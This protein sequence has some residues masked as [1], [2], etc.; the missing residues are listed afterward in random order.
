MIITAL[1]E[2]TTNNP[3]LGVEHGLSL[4]IEGAHKNILFD[5]GASDLFYQNAKLLKIDLR[6]VDVAVLSHGHYDHSGGISAFF[7]LNNKAPLYLRKE[8]FS[9]FYSEREDG[10]Y[11][12]IGIDPSLKNAN[13]LMFTSAYTPIAEGISLFSKV[14]QELFVPQGNAS[15]FRKNGEKYE[16]DSF[17]HE[18]Y[19][20]V[21]EGE[22]SLLVSGCS[23]RGIVNILASFYEKWGHYPDY[24]IGGFHLY[25]HRTGEPEKPQ[26]LKNI[27]DILSASKAQFYTCHCTGEENFKALKSLMGDQIEYLRGGDEI[28]IRN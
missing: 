21:E 9:P 10:Q 28:T 25:N 13:R 4:Y 20:V 22:K 16:V 14:D 26:V 2:N 5:T 12:F 8:A 3:S 27:A 1:L 7:G 23:H 24:V 19:L 15:L 18:Q 11:H 6:E 17:S